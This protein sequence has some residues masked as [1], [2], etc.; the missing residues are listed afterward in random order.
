MTQLPFD[1][2]CKRQYTGKQLIDLD[3]PRI[4]IKKA[5]KNY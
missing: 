1:L 2:V 4:T 5:I 3:Y